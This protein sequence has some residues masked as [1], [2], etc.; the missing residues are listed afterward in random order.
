LDGLDPI[1][2]GLFLTGQG[3]VNYYRERSPVRRRAEKLAET[4]IGFMMLLC[5][6]ACAALFVFVCAHF[7]IKDW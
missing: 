1:Q 6:V 4:F 5:L 2:A 3:H 7:V